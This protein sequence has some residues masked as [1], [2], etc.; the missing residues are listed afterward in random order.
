MS[1]TMADIALAN[2]RTP[3]APEVVTPT[4][5]ADLV[6]E[7]GWTPAVGQRPPQVR[8]DS[9]GM[10]FF[11]GVADSSGATADAFTTLPIQLRV[12]DV[13]VTANVS[14]FATAGLV[15]RVVNVGVNGIVDVA[16]AFGEPGAADATLTFFVSRF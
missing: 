12:L 1:S 8:M 10:L 7:N 2:S 13:S 11:Q 4:P 16:G 9:H 14:Q 6:L 3:G 15:N 5:W